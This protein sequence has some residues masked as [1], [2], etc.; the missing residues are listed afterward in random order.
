MI[1]NKNGFVL[2]NVLFLLLVLSGITFSF[3]HY[4]QLNLNILRQSLLLEKQ[5][6]AELILYSYFVSHLHTNESQT[7]ENSNVQITYTIS[8][9]DDRSVLNSRICFDTCYRWELEYDLEN[10]CMISSEY[11]P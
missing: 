1:V 8:A 3:A 9:A 11:M 7:I 5:K 10:K 6:A 4:Y 2:K